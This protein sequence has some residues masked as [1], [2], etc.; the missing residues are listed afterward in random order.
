MSDLFSKIFGVLNVDLF[1][2]TWQRDFPHS[3]FERLTYFGHKDPTRCYWEAEMTNPE[4]SEKIDITM[5]GT[6]DGPTPAE[7]EFCE[8]VISDLDGLFV[9]CRSAFEAEFIAW[10]EHPFPEKWREAFTLVGFS[11]PPQGDTS[12]PWE[13]TYFVEP[14]NH[15]FTAEF[16]SDRVVRVT[17]DG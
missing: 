8:R 14:A 10:A 11:V 16:E 9:K 3:Y 1:R 2:R 15:Y 12:Q 7:Q 4:C 5:Q 6:E 13:V 17:V